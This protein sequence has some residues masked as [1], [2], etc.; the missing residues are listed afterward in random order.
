LHDGEA[1]IVV[2]EG[3]ERIPD[4]VDVHDM[5]FW[6]YQFARSAEVRNWLHWRMVKKIEK[7]LTDRDILW[8]LEEE[9]D[10]TLLLRW[11]ARRR[12]Q[13]SGGVRRLED[14]EWQIRKGNY[15]T[16]ADL[17]RF[18]A[19]QVTCFHLY[20]MY[21]SLDIYIHRRNHPGAPRLP[22]KRKRR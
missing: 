3:Y 4:G 17:F 8:I 21:Q 7:P 6:Q 2:D 16:L 11:V 19:R 5:K 15:I 9:Q 14:G 10:R 13:A 1:R 18:G 22:E 20:R 12:N